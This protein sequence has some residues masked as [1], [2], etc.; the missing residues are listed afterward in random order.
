MNSYLHESKPASRWLEAYAMGNGHI[1]AMVYGGV[2]CD[3][4][5]MNDDTLYSGKK[6][7][8]DAP[9]GAAHI[10]EIRKLILEDRN[11]EAYDACGKYL[12][13]DPLFVRS[14]QEVCDVVLKSNV[15]GVAEDYKRTLDM[16]TG[17]AS[18]VYTLNGTKIK[19]EYFISFDKDVMLVKT[20]AEK[21][22]LDIS[23]SMKRDRDCSVRAYEN[24]VVLNGQL[25]DLPTDI[26]GEGGSNMR[27][28]AALKVFSDG[29]IT[30]DDEQKTVTA[31]GA[32]YVTVV[33]S[34][35][36]DYDFS[37]L[38]LDRSIEPFAEAKKKADAIADAD[39]DE[40]KRKNS[41]FI[42]ELYDRVSLKLDD[43]APELDITELQANAR[44]GRYI[45][46]LVEKTFNFGRYLLITSSLKPGTLPA[47][48]QGIWGEGYDMPWNADFHT[49]I[50]LQMNYWPAHVC[51]LAETAEPLNDFLEKL[52]IPG[53]ET[54]KNMYHAGGWTLHHLVDC[55]G[56]TCMHDG[57]WGATPLSGPWLSRHLWEHY[58]FTGDMDFLKNKAYPILEGASRF[59]LDYMIDDG[60][61]RLVTAPSASPENAFLLNGVRTYLT[62]SST[63]DVE[64]ILDI[65][66]KTVAAAKLLGKE[67]DAI[68]NEIREALPRL[69]K[70]R[71]SEKYGNLCE[72]IEDYEET[73]LGHRHVSHLYGLYPADVITRK[74]MTIFNAA[75][76]AIDRRLENGGAGTG[77]SRAWTISFFAR[78]RD[79]DAAYYHV[80]EFVK[81]CCE[82]NLFD[83]HPPFQIDGNFGFT[84]GVAEMLVQSHD[85]EACDRTISI[86]PALPS[87][88]KNGSVNGLKARGNIDVS[89]EWKNGKAVK[90]VLKPVF[91]TVIKVECDGI[92]EM[93][94]TFETTLD[95]NVAR[96]NAVA[97]REYVFYIA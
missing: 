88:W 91:D 5:K 73:E 43:D 70:L 80:S 24:Y 37:Q 87:E 22:I 10:D 90:V 84:A 14:Y 45:N 56:K 82:N 64:I 47:N 68:I 69:P 28:A 50:N 76:K 94:H 21:P 97:G 61:G 77:W 13:G 1:G 78:F 92:G 93:K 55:F 83:M 36:T 25:V 44:E 38:S 66:D 59:L 74:D 27:F 30:A 12:L 67:N 3:S 31:K 19:R 20:I 6:M 33:Y 7:C 49:N 9:D 15:E 46:A 54:A 48:L 34:S 79:G 51:N 65:F 42:A 32:S 57:V 2:E 16:R 60:T 11:E 18:A 39:Y 62:Y 29:E 58:E 41:E 95:G 52:T 53:A 8:A 23:V 17:V 35:H 71:V 89:M 72:W 96:F 86:L 40:Y 26:Q 85:G 4:I 75:R 81:K 63:M